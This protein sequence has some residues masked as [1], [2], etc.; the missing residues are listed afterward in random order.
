VGTQELGNDFQ[1]EFFRR[2]KK[3]RH[4]NGSKGGQKANGSLRSDY[5]PE[6]IARACELQAAESDLSP[7]LRLGYALIIKRLLDG[8]IS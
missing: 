7:R 2:R 4:G 1:S 5:T 8:T 6:L 3:G